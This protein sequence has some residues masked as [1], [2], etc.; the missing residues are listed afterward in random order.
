MSDGNKN[1]AP[2]GPYSTMKMLRFPGLAKQSNVADDKNKLLRS[3]S[4]SLMSRQHNHAHSHH[5]N[6]NVDNQLNNSFEQFTASC[7]DAWDH[8]I[9]DKISVNRTTSN[10]HSSSGDGT[11]QANHN[12]RLKYG[13]VPSIRIKERIDGNGGPISG[14]L[15]SSLPTPVPVPE[16]TQVDVKA[17]KLKKLIYVDEVTD[18]NALRTICWNGITNPGD[19]PLAWKLLLGQV[20]PIKSKRSTVLANKKQEYQNLVEQYYH[21]RQENDEVYRQIHIDIPRMQ[22]LLSIFQQPLVQGIFERI[23][24]IWSIRHPASGY[25]QVSGARIHFHFE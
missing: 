5:N 4:E 20:P 13:N 12:Q 14:S 19:R 2:S 17:S 15:P 3:T 1:P 16:P 11:S 23:L 21:N 9:D 18:M 6:N 24:Y 22:P 7:D 25:V 8:N 10:G